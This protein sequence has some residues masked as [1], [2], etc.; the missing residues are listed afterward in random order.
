MASIT[1]AAAQSA[2]IPNNIRANVAQHLV[3]ARA[4]ADCGVSFLIFPELSLT[5]YEL[6]SLAQLALNPDAAALDPLRTLAQ[7]AHMTLVVGAPLA[8]P[9]GGKPSIG[10]ICLR[11]DGTTATY[12]KRFLHSGEAAFATAG[13]VNAKSFDLN[14]ERISIAIC[15]DTVNPDHPRWAAEAGATVYAAGVLWSHAGYDADAAQIKA[16]CIQHGF[17]ALVANHAAPTGGYVAA[18]KSAFWAPGGQLLCTAPQEAPALLLA[19]RSGNVWTS[20]STP[21]NPGP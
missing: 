5:G 2:S 18:G 16:H 8:C 12:R 4:A 17:A 15:A 21:V 1:L 20:R 10:S 7:S 13:S 6:P 19:Q 14:G 3:F 11:P 9:Q